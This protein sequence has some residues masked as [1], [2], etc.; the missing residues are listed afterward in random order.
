MNEEMFHAI[1]SMDSYNRGIGADIFIESEQI[2]DATVYKDTGDFVSIAAESVLQGFYAI[3]YDYNGSK[4]VSY[5]GTDDPIGGYI[6]DGDIWNGWLVGGGLVHNNQAELAFKFYQEVVDGVENTFT[7]NVSFT[8]HSLGGGLAG[9]V[10]GA[11]GKE[12]IMFDNMPFELALQNT[13]DLA[14]E[15]GVF[16]PELEALV[17]GAG[18]AVDSETSEHRTIS[19][20]G[21]ALETFR[22]LQ[23]TIQ[24]P[25]SLGE[26]VDLG[27]VE[28]HSMSAL[29]MRMFVDASYNNEAEYTSSED[30]LSASEH[31]WEV[32]YNKAGT[33]YNDFAKQI[34]LE[35]VEGG[36]HAVELGEKPD[37]SSVLRDII[38]YSAINEGVRVFGDT[39][40]RSFWDDANELGSALD[41]A[42][43][44]ELFV[45]VRDYATDI[46]KAFIHF[47][48]Q[49]GIAKIEK[50][51]ALSSVID[52]VLTHNDT[53]ENKSLIIDFTHGKWAS[54]E[55]DNVKLSGMFTRDELVSKAINATGSVVNAEVYTQMALVWG[56]DTASAFDHVVFAAY[57]EE[58]GQV[59]LSER[60]V[61]SLA[62]TATG[63]TTGG[64]G[65]GVLN[66]NLFIGGLGSEKVY[67]S[68]GNDLLLGGA[69]A[70]GDIDTAV[71]LNSTQ[72]IEN[73]TFN[74]STVVIEHG[75]NATD[76]LVDFEEIILTSLDDRVS[77]PEGFSQE[78]T[79]DGAGGVD[80]LDFSSYTQGI[81]VNSADVD[82]N[83]SVG[84]FSFKDFEFVIGTAENDVFKGGS[85]SIIFDGSDHVLGTFGDILDYSGYIDPSGVSGKPTVGYIIVDL[86]DNTV[87]KSDNINGQS[88][89]SFLNIEAFIGTQDSDYFRAQEGLVGITFDGFLQNDGGRDVV[90]F[91]A[92]SNGVT[93]TLD[94][95][96]TDALGGT[97]N[98]FDIEEV[99][100]T[101]SDDVLVG[102]VADEW[103]YGY[104]SFDTIDGKG[105]DDHIWG[106]LGYNQLFGGSGSDIFSYSNNDADIA[107][108]DIYGGSG[109]DTIKLSGTFQFDL[110]D[111]SR[112][113]ASGI[114]TI[115]DL[116][117]L[118]DGDVEFITYSDGAIFEL[119]HLALEAPSNITN[120]DHSTEQTD[121]D[122]V[123]T[124]NDSDNDVFR[125]SIGN[126]TINGGVGGY[127]E[128]TYEFYVPDAFGNGIFYNESIVTKPNTTGSG[129][130]FTDTLESIE[131]IRGTSG[132]DQFD[133]SAEDEQFYGGGG[134]DVLNGGEGNDVLY[135]GGISGT[136]HTDTGIDILNGGSGD[137]WLYGNGLDTLHGHGGS[138]HLYG[139]NGDLVFGD[140][141][142]DFLFGT[143]NAVL[144]GGAGNDYLEGGGT[145]IESD[146][147]DVISAT[148]G[149][150]QMTSTSLSS[151]VFARAENGSLVIIKPNG[152]RI[153][154]LDHF[155]GS[156]IAFI[157]DGGTPEDIANYDQDLDFLNT[158]DD[159]VLVGTTGDDFYDSEESGDDSIVSNGGTNTYVFD[160]NNYDSQTSVFA[161]SS[162]TSLERIVLEDA[163]S[164]NDF[165]LVRYD[166]SSTLSLEYGAGTVSLFN[167]GTSASQYQV[168][169]GSGSSST[170]HGLDTLDFISKGS[171]FDDVLT[172]DLAGL[173][174]DD[175]IYALAGDDEIDGGEGS[176]TIY[177]GLGND[178]LLG[179][180]DDDTLYGGAGDDEIDGGAGN[181]TLVDGEGN[182]TY[183]AS[184]DDILIVGSGHNTLES[185]L[186]DLSTFTIDVSAFGVFDSLSGETDMGFVRSFSSTIQ[187]ET[188]AFYNDDLVLSYGANTLTLDAYKDYAASP[189]IEMADG[190]TASLDSLVIEG[191][192][193]DE[194]DFY[195]EQNFTIL[196][197]DLIYA[198]DGNDNF[199]FMHGTDVVYGGAG[200]DTL[201]KIA[202]FS[203]TVGTV[204]I[205]VPQGTGD[206]I[207]YGEEGDDILRGGTG[208]DILKGGIG[209]DS[210]TDLVGGT[211]LL[212]GGDGDDFFS[213]G[214]QGGATVEGGEGIDT[215]AVWSANN[216]SVATPSSFTI[217]LDQQIIT[218]D[219]GSHTLSSI[220]N[221]Y[222]S[223]LNDVIIGD[224][225]SNEI[226]GYY[227]D[228]DLQG[229]G[230]SDI[231]LF[232]GN[233]DAGDEEGYDGNDVI[234]D[235]GGDDDAIYFGALVTY[236]DLA[237]T[238]S[239]LDLVISYGSSSVTIENQ[240]DPG[241]VYVIENINFADGS[242]LSL[243]DYSS[244]IT[245][246]NT[247]NNP[248]NGTSNDDI[249]YALDGNDVVFGLT[250]H[251]SLH[252][253][254]GDD[255]LNGE[256]DDDTL[257]GGLGNDV[258]DG[259]S[260]LD[261]ASYLGAAAI[262]ANLLTNLVDDGYGTQDTLISVENV[263]GSFYN[264]I[265]VSGADANVFDGHGGI[266]TV[267]YQDSSIKVHVDLKN[268]TTSYGN[269]EGDVLVSI[270]NITGSDFSSQRDKIYGD[271]QDNQILGMA[272]NDILEG[273]GGADLIDGGAGWDYARYTRSSAGININL[274]TNINTGGDAEGD[275]ILNT[276][277]ITASNHDDVITG[278]ASGNYIQGKNGNDYLDGNGGADILFGDGGDDTF[279][280]SSGN[281]IMSETTGTDRIVFDSIWRPDQV[282]VNGS[283]MSFEGSTDSIAFNTDISLF[284]EFEF[285]G[286]GVMDLATLIAYNPDAPDTVG[287]V[288]DNVFIATGAAEQ[289]DG[290]G[291][292]DT[293]SYENSLL[294]VTVDLLSN[295][296]SGGDAQG[297]SY[298]D[299]ENVTGSDIYHITG[300][301]TSQ[302]RDFIYGDESVN[303]L[304]GLAGNDILEGDGGADTIDG[305][306][307]WDY[308]RYTRSGSAVTINLETGIN[309][310]GDAEGDVLIGIEAITGSNYDDTLTGGASND[311]LNGSPGDDVLNGRA[312]L[313]VLIGGSGADTFILDMLG[314]VDIIADFSV[315]ENDI[316]DIRDLFVIQY[317]ETQDAINDFIQ[318]TDDG[319]H[320]TLSVDADGGGDSFVI[321]ATVGNV[322]GLDAAAL[323][324]SDNLLLS[325]TQV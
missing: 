217:D 162:G 260:G 243:L 137:D 212:D 153:I 38:A 165:S 30:W 80:V 3:S 9:L 1:L 150:L 100:A 111:F 126:D 73:I 104:A 12:A 288:L 120:V 83:L 223:N 253:G 303:I 201:G 307:G 124:G 140:D 7:T 23:Q 17:F 241:G 128:V 157:S 225:L 204:T 22:S 325:D 156:G 208:N 293:V 191:Y 316:L 276:E 231:Y 174:Q 295:T 90:D 315:A 206:F 151:L 70:V 136:L 198:G 68:A 280:F 272:G 116:G 106:G 266:D 160:S 283:F 133:G 203:I 270:E 254:S 85:S 96:S 18:S 264:D 36:F 279:F 15:G 172:G 250:G 322:I 211:D 158:I 138:D 230:G 219:I 46:S 183:L 234:L 323:Y 188:S 78:I 271:A 14:S 72:G 210:L 178:I 65:E 155:N 127:D 202:G 167:A 53:A 194:S 244:W 267:S 105:G 10:G 94:N 19:T 181:D 35:K 261:T 318:F 179:G 29:V 275:V 123:L 48:G 44:D 205:S 142:S 236:D 97:L 319:E 152:D 84:D 42:L 298:N 259:G 21:E 170:L 34:L 182:D 141:G 292:V 112:A 163:T 75:L 2:G 237:F 115:A 166:N 43:P 215:V 284:E 187:A 300:S 281:V 87:S 164:L 255:T 265:F 257:D 278:N 20:S 216:D 101:N 129:G 282:I 186:T 168:Q 33:D 98:V 175:V 57:G 55:S 302:E 6:W 103:F 193:S 93:L 220:E 248:F 117:T 199:Q 227:G 108:D 16:W 242:S 247:D 214:V 239:G 200:I 58:G 81:T 294:G 246:D 67:S 61:S 77:L 74:D 149:T 139:E 76:I 45:A 207:A 290:L 161:F 224:S 263:T 324:A 31:F 221:A 159:E 197:N 306:D 41:A 317:D 8:G 154:V 226:G 148:G 269:A 71:Y 268:N 308:A 132:N 11:Y 118:P 147:I 285:F 49:L 60:A 196:L 79:I 286:F 64:V 304:K 171:L 291:G 125:A 13:I 192:G 240:L 119:Q 252:G 310:G 131:G 144:D 305:G 287:D 110:D 32:L 277:A 314:A 86:T 92:Y 233:G 122:D 63:T 26:G 109:T 222:G 5:R 312:G 4:I 113:E 56:N 301:D 213:L 28:K 66:A 82:G 320:S 245:A 51:S 299:I 238:T 218:S 143:G 228:D 99:H 69:G 121:G 27:S 185:T 289:F 130:A 184:T 309:T 177:G 89:E 25:L 296:G 262:S 134:D 95:S 91:T 107:L 169:I 256:G 274:E 62:A 258:L 176:D 311:Y 189:F 102:T 146:G 251:D 145:F 50:E 47:S 273:G 235:T 40:I 54:A 180:N 297:D 229:G 249:L 52:G 321:A 195:S 135:A 39:A 114:L 190:S 59:L 313:D 232:D 88:I 173:S 24:F 209:N 37:Y